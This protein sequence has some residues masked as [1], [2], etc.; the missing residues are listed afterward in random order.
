MNRARACLCV[1][2]TSGLAS[3]SVGAV[4]DGVIDVLNH[5]PAPMYE[6]QSVVRVTADS[7]REVQAALALAESLWSER[8][9]VGAFD[10]QVRADRIPVLTAA[11]LEVEVRIADLQAQ[12]DA[13]WARVQA[14]ERALRDRPL[15]MGERGAGVHDESWFLNYRQL[16]EI[17]AYVDG[18]AA[19]RP[20]L[21]EQ[22]V[23]G[24][25]VEGRAIRSVTI[26]GP[27]Q[28]GN[29]AADR[30]VI[31]WNG[32][33]HAR[34]WVSPM[35]VTY[36]A[37]R[38]IGDYQTDPA[39]RDL[40]DRVRFVIVPVSNP[41]GYLYTW[42]NDRYW[43]K[44]RRANG[45]GS[46]GVDL[47]RNWGY[48]WGGA[49]TS[50]SPGSDVYRG[51]SAFSE[52][53]TRVLR[54]LGLSFGDD[55]A[56][57]IDYHTYSQLILYPFGYADGVFAPE[58]DR[59]FFDTLATD[60]SD[61]IWDM[62]GVFYNP[63]PSWEL[64]PAAGTASDWFY[65]AA[66]AKSLT[67]ELRPD[68][69]DFDGFAPPP[70]TIL[71]TARENWAAALLF[72]GRTTQALSFVVEAPGVVAADEPTEIGFSVMPGT[73]DYD[74]SGVLVVAAVGGG[75]PV[76]IAASPAG[77]GSFTATL[78]PVPCGQS[79]SYFVRV[80]TTDGSAIDYPA[81]GPLVADAVRVLFEDEMETDTGW[82]VGAPGDTASS[83][84]WNRMSPQ[85]TAAQPGAD[86][87]P[88]GTDCWITDGRAGSG[89][90]SYDVDGGATTLTSP[91][92]DA[93]EGGDEATLVYWRWYSNDAGA[94]PN[95]DSM[96][97]EISGDDGATWVTLE[98]V[99]EN[100]NAWV[101]KRFRIADFV[102]PTDAV[103][104]RFVARDDAPGSIVE[105]AVDDLRIESASCP[106][107]QTADLAEPFGQFNFFDVAAY[108]A[109]YNDQD[110]AA[111]YDGNGV[112]NFFDLG[113][114]LDLY[115]AG[116]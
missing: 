5:T 68:E 53:E 115:N 49:G 32:C 79:V 82:T 20:D 101:E 12:A 114:F 24:Q 41:D 94:S 66:G 113:A 57:H 43:R 91:R 26:T 104:V 116:I 109:L 38:L 111:D 110:A 60:M 80:E 19:A 100:A 3:G 34:E 86:R 58:P 16:A 84:V 63:I 48:E 98:T 107:G 106:G 27:D 37:S 81:S 65:G 83:G 21:T 56:A 97:V 23:I 55:L 54:D 103:R 75:D 28:P 4:D 13:A 22:G 85:A 96:P 8:A 14:A 11:G 67:I 112:L 31:I 18:L 25:S 71:P 61:L 47:N 30:P 36:I 62:S 99:T 29:A 95:A 46:F 88:G 92:L 89:V 74:P 6:G 1:C 9:G 102:A 90:G 59:T 72:A 76:E 93:S 78:P 69:N 17:Q 52:P 35:T 87:T 64:Y 73:A 77:P 51:P 7:A 10:V 70:S 108:L 44:N 33:Q 50:G 15:A 45:S 42:S 40:V 2:L 39:V 105:A